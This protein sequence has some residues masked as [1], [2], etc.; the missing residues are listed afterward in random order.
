MDKIP[1]WQA[2][3][4]AGDQEQLLSHIERS[5]PVRLIAALSDLSVALAN[6]PVS[7]AR[8][9]AALGGTLKIDDVS[10]WMSAG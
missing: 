1:Q 10:Y 3:V 4:L 6:E 2:D 7:A 9:R 5:A 8:T